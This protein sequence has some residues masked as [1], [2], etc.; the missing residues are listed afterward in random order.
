MRI[1][2]ECPATDHYFSLKAFPPNTG[3]QTIRD[4]EVRISPNVTTEYSEDSFGNRYMYGKIPFA[5][6]DFSIEIT[7]QAETGLEL[8]E[9]KAR[10]D[11][12]KI[13]IFRTQSRYTQMGEEL[14]RYHAAL[15]TDKEESV[16]ERVLF[17]M[18]AIHRDFEYKKGTTD[19]FTTAEDAM[20]LHAGVCQDFAH[21]FLAL[22]RA[23]KIPAR[24]VVGMIDEEG[25]SHA[26]VEA[27]CGGYWYGFDPT[28]NLLVNDNYV[29][30]SHGRDFP[31]CRI[32]RG[33]F[34]GGGRQEQCVS[35]SV[36][37]KTNAAEI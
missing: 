34:M 22:L 15:G 32:N 8:F 4:L 9:E 6:D 26:W 14:K 3:R 13:M 25:E 11:D 30:I 17:L 16:Y 35:V 31:D 12:P 24:Y 27:L 10:E 23:E 37:K 18:N 33:I 2:F 29:K 20:K 1:L 5:H 36:S 28:N 7:G 21:V 19:V